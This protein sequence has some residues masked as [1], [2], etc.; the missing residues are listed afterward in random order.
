MPRRPI[1][2]DQK[3]EYLSILD[4]YGAVDETL[5]PHL[6]GDKLL[7]MHRMLLTT[8][9]LDERLLNM[10]R[11]GRIGTYAPV[12]G[13]EA[14]QIGSVVTVKPSDWVVQ[15]FREPGCC[16][17]RGWPISKI[18]QF[19]GGYEEG[20]AVPEGI[21]DTPIA[22]PVATQMPHITG[23]AWAMKIKGKDDVALGYVG[24]GGTSEGDFH[25]A[26]TFAGVFKV[27]AVFIIVNNQWAI[28]YPRSRQT[29]SKTLAQKALAY[30]M[31]GIQVDGNDVLA[32]YVAA[33]EAV[34]KARK[35]GGPTLIE[36]ITYRLA[37]HTTADDPKKYRDDAE[38]KKW[39][40]RDP[41]PRFTN[42]L[43]AKG[44]LDD[45]T[46]E[47]VEADVKEQIKAGVEEYEANRSVDPLDSFKY[48][49]NDLPAELI[50]QRQEFEAALQREGIGQGH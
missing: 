19:W 50:A 25:E 27:P 1:K 35:G 21:N 38:V 7:Y 48:I 12:R 29:A 39:E 47:A 11:Q 13:Q 42:Y 34:E 22:V 43:M 17:H 2:L 40:K 31:D 15:T 23:L 6:D 3:L 44:V 32:V 46:L 24:D 49:Y 36:A 9:R 14:V 37:M 8:R 5:D 41:L 10:Q 33:S 4:E 16:L 18:L 45:K 30:G 20:C 28:S 26:L